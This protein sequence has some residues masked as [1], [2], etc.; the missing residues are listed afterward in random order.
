MKINDILTD[1]VFGKIANVD[2]TNKKVTFEKPDGSKMDVSTANVM[3]DPAHP[4]NVTVDATATAAELKPGM[5]AT[6][7]DT[8]M[9]EELEDELGQNRDTVASGNQDVGGKT[10]DKT[11]E[12]IKQIVG[13]FDQANHAV[14]EGPEPA[15]GTP[16][17]WAKVQSG[18][19][20]VAPAP[21]PVDNRPATPNPAEDAY[22]KRV[23]AEMDARSKANPYKAAP[24]PNMRVKE[25]ADDILLNKML[26]IAGIK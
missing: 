9:P 1:A 16:E 3:P 22:Y 25:S 14:E 4:G 5:T 26:N 13:D 10:G 2:T 19:I 24:M 23:Q 21:M 15:F 11:D 20:K 7:S 6:T 18:E 8:S 17:Y 12:L